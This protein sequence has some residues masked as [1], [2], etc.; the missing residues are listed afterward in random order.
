MR[1]T[2][3]VEDSLDGFP[4]VHVS[5]TAE[6]VACCAEVFV[7]DEGCEKDF[8][9]GDIVDGAGLLAG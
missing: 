3:E 7:L 4:G 2:L 9:H 5:E 1:W 6:D 8:V